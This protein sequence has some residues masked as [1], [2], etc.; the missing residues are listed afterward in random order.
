[1]TTLLWLA[2]GAMAYMALTYVVGLLC[3]MASDGED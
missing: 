2:V 1:M 3:S